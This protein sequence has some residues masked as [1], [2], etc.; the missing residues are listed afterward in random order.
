MDRSACGSANLAV[1]YTLRSAAA[2]GSRNLSVAGGPIREFPGEP[3]PRTQGA[4]SHEP[5]T[6]L[7]TA[8]RTNRGNRGTEGRGL[9]DL[10]PPRLGL[11]E[12]TFGHRSFGR[13][14]LAPACPVSCRACREQE[15]DDGYAMYVQS[16]RRGHRVHGL[17]RSL[18]G[19]V[20]R[21]ETKELGHSPGPHVS[22][23]QMSEQVQAGRP[24][25]PRD[26][27][28]PRF[29]TATPMCPFSS[30]L[31]SCS[32][33][34]EFV[35][36]RP[37]RTLPPLVAFSSL[38]LLFHVSILFPPPTTPRL[39]PL[40]TDAARAPRPRDTSRRLTARPAPYTQLSICAAPRPAS[41]HTAR[42]RQDTGRAHRKN[43]TAFIVVPHAHLCP[44]P[45]LSS[46]PLAPR[47]SI[48]P[49]HTLA[50]RCPAC[51]S[52]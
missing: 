12:L 47:R 4:G 17:A 23:C 21:A 46:L 24:G 25:G 14:E 35:I 27:R 11:R 29:T 9:A 2:R 36:Y 50:Q 6:R 34:L 16:D 22:S 8:P 42:L 5:G 10:S 51:V 13:L 38:I 1:H 49:Q 3:E 15:W 41:P 40:L 39:A 30:L 31:L 37:R 20:D 28:D 26:P 45:H 43:T 18:G 52:A 48:N 7:I 32:G 33:S 44:S 19:P